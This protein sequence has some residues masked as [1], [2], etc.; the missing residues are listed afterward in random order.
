[1]EGGVKGIPSPFIKIYERGRDTP[2]ATLC[3]LLPCKDFLDEVLVTP[4]AAESFHQ[5]NRRGELLAMYLHRQP[6]VAEQNLLRRDHFEIGGHAALLAIGGDVGCVLSALHAGVRLGDGT[7][8]RGQ[9]R[10]P[11][12]HFFHGTQHRLP[13]GRDG[14]GVIRARDAHV[15]RSL[16]CVEQCLGGRQPERP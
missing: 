1:M 3:P 16:P 7:T 14:G 4:A 10:D 11:V 5:E 8:E 2:H 15:R 12:L 13:V 6:L 9:A